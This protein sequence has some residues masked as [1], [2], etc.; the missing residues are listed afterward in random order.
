MYNEADEV[1]APHT[2][3]LGDEEL[4]RALLTARRV[5]NVLEDRWNTHALAPAFAVKVETGADDQPVLVFTITLALND[6]FPLDEWPADEIARIKSDLRSQ[7]GEADLALV[8]WYVTVVTEGSE[9][10]DD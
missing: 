4:S 9:K 1:N 6:D 7:A 5:C 8:D 2:A 3:L 10:V